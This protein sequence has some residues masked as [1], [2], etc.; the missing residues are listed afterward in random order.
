MRAFVH[1]E[2][3]EVGRAVVPWLLTITRRLCIDVARKARPLSSDTLD[4][5]EPRAN[6]EAELGAREQL[7]VL[8]R[9]HARLTDGPREAIALYHWEHMSYDEIATTLGVPIGTVMTWLHRGRAQLRKALTSE[10][11]H[12]TH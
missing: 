8:R 10:V 7:E 11:R 6:A 9:A 12:D 4:T 2:R 3:F 1:R 5:I